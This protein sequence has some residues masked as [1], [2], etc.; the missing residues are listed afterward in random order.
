[1]KKKEENGLLIKISDDIHKD[2]YYYFL[3]A[4]WNEIY[5][6]EFKNKYYRLTFNTTKHMGTDIHHNALT[7]GFA[8]ISWNQSNYVTFVYTSYYFA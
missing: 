5:K 2:E 6:V 8:N 7:K 1:M 3:E 4:K